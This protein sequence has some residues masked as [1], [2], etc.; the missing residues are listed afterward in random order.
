[1]LGYLMVTSK[2]KS[3]SVY[4]PQIEPEVGHSQNYDK[5]GFPEVHED[6]I[7]IN[8]S[9]YHSTGN[10]ESNPKLTEI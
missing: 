6:A 1:M 5:N 7:K 10:D 2:L 4:G 9:I 8:I 3:V